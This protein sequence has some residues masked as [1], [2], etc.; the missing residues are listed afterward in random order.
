MNTT[1]IVDEGGE[2]HQAW[3]E[4]VRKREDGVPL[5]TVANHISVFDDPGLV[6][7]IVPW[8]SPLNPGTWAPNLGGPLA[9]PAHSLPAS[10]SPTLWCRDTLEKG[11]SKD[12]PLFMGGRGRRA[13][14]LS[15]A[16]TAPLSMT[17]LF[18]TCSKTCDG[19]VCR[20]PERD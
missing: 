13:R 14:G 11:L 9:V 16:G 17:S 2:H 4:S 12:P 8:C 5:I 3:L 19:L 10:H 1:T 18:Y 7:T 15:V 20:I 6:G